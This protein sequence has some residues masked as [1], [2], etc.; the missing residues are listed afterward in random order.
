MR[1]ARLVIAGIPNNHV[2]ADARALIGE[3]GVGG[4]ILFKRNI[5]SPE[6]T[7]ELIR[8]LKSLRKEPLWVSVDQEGGRVQR[9]RA[10]LT[11]FPPMRAVGAAGEAIAEAV[12]AQLALEL[13]AVGFDLDFAPVVDVDSNP[14]NPVIA[15]RAFA[16]DAKSVSRLA[17]A[18]IHG[19]QK[20]GVQGC[21]KHFPGHGDT[22]EDSH[23]ELPSLP[24]TLD[25][26]RE[27]EWPPFAA[28]AKAGVASIMTAH[29][30]FPA[31]D[32]EWPATLSPAILSALRNELGFRGPVISDDLEMNAIAERYSIPDAAVQAVRAG[33]DALLVCHQRERVQGVVAALARAESNGTL[34][35]D[36][37]REAHGR[38][39]TLR[40]WP[41]A[42]GGYVP[43]PAPS[44]AL[45][46]WLQA[47]RTDKR[48][49]PT[50][51]A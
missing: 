3:L 2:C 25:R 43:A 12:G 26:L 44:G 13:K 23:L 15:D 34:S 24:H 48:V 32:A 4:I 41:A 22:H 50:E 6:Q 5:E 45:A 19:L 31:L 11:D 14:A 47:Q 49:D 39:D 35:K 27:V 16:G 8:E 7:Y 37:L 30:M 28:A 17:T 38:L 51:R 46:E 20:N 9:L 42:D 29:V 36:R 40:A 1:S 21:A 18:F 10:P 33:C